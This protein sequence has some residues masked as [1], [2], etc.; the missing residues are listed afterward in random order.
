MPCTSH[1]SIPQL[2]VTY[3]IPRH[4]VSVTAH[5]LSHFIPLTSDFMTNLGEIDVNSPPLQDV[6][7]DDDNHDNDCDENYEDA[8]NYS[9]HSFH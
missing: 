2:R 8:P 7:N 3:D 6:H 5:H 1:V 4:T 9:S